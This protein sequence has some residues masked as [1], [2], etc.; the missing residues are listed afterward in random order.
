[1]G[2]YLLRDAIGGQDAHRLSR[3][4]TVEMEERWMDDV[5]IV[6]QRFG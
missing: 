3:N 2:L 4:M 6:I 5:T 1:M